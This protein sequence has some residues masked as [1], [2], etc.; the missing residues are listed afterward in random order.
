MLAPIWAA[1][2]ETANRV[3]QRLG[4]VLKW[5]IA[6]GWRETNPVA[7][8][9]GALP[10]R[11]KPVKHHKSLPFDQ[12]AAAIT[13]VRGSAAAES[14]KLAL[15]FLILTATRSGEV[16]NACWDEIDGD[17]WTVSSERMKT[18]KAHRVP[19]SPRCLEILEAAKA[20][21]GGKGYIFPSATTGK[22]LSDATLSKLPL[23]P[24]A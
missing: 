5:S 11:T 24:G 10:K 8:I 23:N 22:A 15:E 7:D 9:E 18:R 12:V 19:L 1:K 4:T 13:T 21:S 14:T 17:T 3:R 20:L 6:Q 16:R 2:P